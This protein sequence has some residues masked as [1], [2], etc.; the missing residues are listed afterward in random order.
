MSQVPPQTFEA[1]YRLDDDPWHFG[2]SPYEQ[3]RFD[4]TIAC[5]PVPRFRRVFEPGCAGGELTVRLSQRCDEIV[6]CDGSATVVARA[7]RRLAVAADPACDIDLVVG[8][9][10]GWWPDGRF[11][12]I[13]LSEVGYYF[14]ATALAALVERLESSLTEGGTLFGVH[15]LGVSADHLLSGDEVHDV[16]D[17][18]TTLVR[19]GGFRDPG[20]RLDWWTSH[21]G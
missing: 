3:R 20:F 13:V 18:S 9:I 5:L 6:A 16:V 11:D 14:D 4:I 1:A 2:T 21:G 10:P 15:W 7:R 19:R 8:A 12:L 17:S